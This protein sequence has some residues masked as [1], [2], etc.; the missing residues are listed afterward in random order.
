MKA[1]SIKGKSPEEIK[2]ALEQSMAD[3]RL[4]DGQGFK[5]LQGSVK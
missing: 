2:I 1:K 3:A 5:T 4:P